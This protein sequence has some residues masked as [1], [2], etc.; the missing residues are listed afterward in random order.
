MLSAFKLP[1]FFWAEAITTA[2]YTHNRSLIAPRHEKT[3]YHIIY[4][5]K[6]SLKHVHIFG[7]TCY[8]TRDGKN[9]NKM[10]KKGDQWIMVG[11]HTKS[12]RYRVYNKRTRLIVESIHINFDEIMELS[13]TPDDNTSGLTYQLQ[14]TS[15]HNRSE[16]ET[17]KHNNEPS[18]S[19]LVPNV[20]PL[21][22]K[23]DKSLQELDFIFSPF[24]EEYFT[25][26]NQSVS[27]SSALSD[28]FEHQ[29]TQPTA[30]VQPTTEQFTPTTTV[31][32]EENNTNQAADTQF[33][34]YEFFNPL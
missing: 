17:H 4:D 31:H 13:M 32:A 7:Y 25:A 10:K 2:C 34:P 27:K 5:K 30:N 33:V 24:F 22:D 29:D 1:L 11:Y 21:V 16:L 19:K 8:L 28:N 12:K 14:K 3:P 9:L 6:P 15:D 18:N 20:Y 26:G 23:T